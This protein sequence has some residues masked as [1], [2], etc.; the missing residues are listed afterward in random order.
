MRKPQDGLTRVRLRNGLEVRLMPVRTA[1]LIS[2]W[3]WYRVGSRNEVPGI[4]GASH[5]VEHMQFK[6]TPTFPA[7][8]LD[9]TISRDGGTWNAFTWLDWTAYFETMPADRIDLALRLE[10]DRMVHSLF[11]KR[12][13][14]AERTVVIAERQGHENE[15]TFRLAEEVQ[16][17]R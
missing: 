14:E 13:V 16:G 2:C 9:R 8:E 7:G 17:K 11:N 15:P 4:T 3:I 6:G 12:E 5:W 1:P 10:A